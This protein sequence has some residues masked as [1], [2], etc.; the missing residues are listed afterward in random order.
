MKLSTKAR[1]GLRAVLDLAE[2]Y[3]TGPV[4]AK[5]IAERQGISPKY[6]EHLLSALKA[7]GLVQ[8]VRGVHGGYKLARPPGEVRL[9]DVVRALEGSLHLVECTDSSGYCPRQDMCVTREVWREMAAA[10]TNIL[11][12]TTVADLIRRYEN[13]RQAAVAQGMYYI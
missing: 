2:Y 13:K 9:G 4:Q 7:S 11:N 6:L 3:G 8:V 10:I 5:L 1:Y 12:N